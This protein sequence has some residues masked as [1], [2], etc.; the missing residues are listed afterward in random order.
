MR[1]QRR[2]SQQINKKNVLVKELSLFE[3]GN[4]NVLTMLVYSSFFAARDAKFYNKD[5]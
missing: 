4:S 3:Q 1:S 5:V 2:G